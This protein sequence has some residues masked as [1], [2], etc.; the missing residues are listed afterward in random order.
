M[1]YPKVTDMQIRNFSFLK[2]RPQA[3]T[4]RIIDSIGSSGTQ[5]LTCLSYSL[6]NR[7]FVGGLYAT[8]IQSSNIPEL[9]KN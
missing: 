8:L 7:T 4:H 6:L 9:L 2:N 3:P 1:K 5:T